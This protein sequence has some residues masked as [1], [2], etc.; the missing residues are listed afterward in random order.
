MLKRTILGVVTTAQKKHREAFSTFYN[1][2]LIA[3]LAQVHE[4]VKLP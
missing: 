4:E 1:W 3:I 2:T